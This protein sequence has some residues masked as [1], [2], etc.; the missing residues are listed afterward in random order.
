MKKMTFLITLTLLL[1]QFSGFSQDKYEKDLYLRKAEKYTNMK[2]AG[3]VMTFGGAAL[4]VLGIS[5]MANSG[6]DSYDPNASSES[7]GKWLAGYFETL[8]GIALTGGGIPLW[9]IGSSKNKKYM[10]MYRNVSLNI[11]P[12][13]GHMLNLTYKF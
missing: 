11:K 7:A 6:Y 12:D 13:A 10:N 3:I 8:G 1:L 4:T 2:T 9:I 5:T